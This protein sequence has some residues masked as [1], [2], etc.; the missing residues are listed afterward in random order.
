MKNN[1][2]YKLCKVIGWPVL[3]WASQFLLLFLIFLVYSLLTN[4]NE[5]ANFINYHS[6]IIGFLNVVI[7]LPIF[8]KKYK[9]YCP[10]DQ[11]KINQPIKIILVAV[12]TS[13]A[14]N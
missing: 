10:K 6:Y 2:F 14:L 12:L 7:F 8:Y 4:S 5:F 9:K 1:Y 11:N 13:S 3:F